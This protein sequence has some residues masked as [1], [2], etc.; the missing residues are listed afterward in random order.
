MPNL[1]SAC[2]FPLALLFFWGTPSVRIV[3][4]FLA[5]L[6]DVFDG[7]LARYL[8]KESSTGVWLDP[9][10]DKFFVVIT[11]AI[12]YQEHS[13]DSWKVAAFFCRD[14]SILLFTLYLSLRGLLFSYRP[15]AIWCGKISTGLQLM[16]LVALTLNAPLPNYIFFTFFFFGSLALVEL[17][18]QRSSTCE[19]F[20][21]SL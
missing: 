9:L 18:T 6:T 4:I 7:F 21:T 14:L 11:L 12:L 13:I 3:I 1:L 15:R 2:R 16:V 5:F 17:Y 10:A 8:K 20:K 19:K